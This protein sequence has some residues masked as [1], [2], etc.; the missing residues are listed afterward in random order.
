MHRVRLSLPHFERH[1]WDPIVLAVDP[2]FVEAGREPMLLKTLP[3]HI[4]IERVKALPAGVTRKVGLGDL[5]LRALPFLYH[6]GA[7]IL[8]SRDI[9]LVYFSTTA[10]SS[11]V[12]G[13][14]W[15]Q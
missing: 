13:R 7:K 6:G 4:P 8:S 2:D 10:F 9:D 3:T 12:L 5:A 11:L 14:L 15:R 1:G